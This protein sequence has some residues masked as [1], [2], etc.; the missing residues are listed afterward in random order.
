[1]MSTSNHP[2][3]VKT[4][5]PTVTIM[6]NGP[7]KGGDAATVKLLRS[8]PSIKDAYQLHKNAATSAADNTEPAL[9]A[10]TDPAGGE[11][12]RVAVAADGARFSVG[13]GADG[14]AREFDSK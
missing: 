13:I 12:I 1:G 2:S 6:N 4:I 8:I 5:A 7:R 14:P 9:I 3:L 11:F 10:N